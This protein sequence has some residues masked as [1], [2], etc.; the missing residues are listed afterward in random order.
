[1][2]GWAL[3]H[4]RQ[5]ICLSIVYNKTKLLFPDEAAYASFY[6]A[7]DYPIT[8]ELRQ[9]VYVD[10]HILERTDPNIILNLERCWATSTS[11]PDSLPQW[12]LLVGG[13]VKTPTN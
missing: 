7:A 11:N 13:Y 2:S 10:V 3:E 1:M 5:I 8:K 4:L 9:S 12:D 6:T